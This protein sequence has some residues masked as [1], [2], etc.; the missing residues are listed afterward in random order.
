MRMSGRDVGE[1]GRLDEIAVRVIALRQTVAAAR[2][3]CAVFVLA[4]L[5][6]AHD[7]VRPRPR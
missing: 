7:L 1:D 2:E 6:V 5:D 3:R 4:D